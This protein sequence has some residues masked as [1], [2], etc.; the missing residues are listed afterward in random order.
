MC[1]P[2]PACA[3]DWKKEVIS[4]SEVIDSGIKVIHISPNFP[5]DN[6]RRQTEQEIA[7]LLSQIIAKYSV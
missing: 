2:E 5:D 6:A 7:Q 3:L 4:I 1:K